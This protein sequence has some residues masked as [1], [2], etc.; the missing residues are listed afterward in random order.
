MKNNMTNLDK[1]STLN[2]QHIRTEDRT[3]LN[4][5]QFILLSV[6]SLGLYNIWWMF[7]AWRFFLQKDQ[8]DIQPAL[9]AIFSIFFLYGLFER[10]RKYAQQQGY[11][12]RFSSGWMF[13]GVMVFSYLSYL[14]APYFILYICSVLF[15]IPAFM[16][17]NYAK[18]HTENIETIE[19]EKFKT[20]HIILMFFGAIMWL[21][22]F[23]SIYLELTGQLQ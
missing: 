22:L 19:Q 14:P 6:L 7:K 11:S 16:A 10:I 20:A 17:L 13:L 8:L 4:L 23:L 18:R 1:T 15:Y 12:K 5:K 2:S 21:L 9:R 3:L